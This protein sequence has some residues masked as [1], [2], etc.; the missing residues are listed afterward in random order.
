[1]TEEPDRQRDEAAEHEEPEHGRGSLLDLAR[2]IVLGVRDTGSE[3]AHEARQRARLTRLEL[4]QR[5]DEKARP[6]RQL[7]PED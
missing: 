7:P 3:M 5:Y 1:M 4:W 2:A 6:R